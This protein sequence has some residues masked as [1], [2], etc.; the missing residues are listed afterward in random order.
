MDGGRFRA[1]YGMGQV[2]DVVDLSEECCRIQ[3]SN[4]IMGQEKSHGESGKWKNAS[5][6]DLNGYPPVSWS[7][8]GL[9]KSEKIYKR[10][11]YAAEITP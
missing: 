6:F 10:Q 5:F 9:I 7:V 11:Q 2:R 8:D 1:T 4:V 3:D